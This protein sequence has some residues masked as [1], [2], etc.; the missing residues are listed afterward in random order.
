MSTKH[1]S[2]VLVLTSTFPRG[3]DDTIP[4][5]VLHLCQALKK[6]GWSSWV[7]APHAHGLKTRDEVGGI[8]CRRF[9]YAPARWE[10]LAYGGGMLANVRAERWRWLLLPSYL[11]SLLLHAAWLIGRRDIRIVHAHW[12]IP[13]GVVATLLKKIFWW[14]RIRVVITAHGGD[15]YSRFGGLA[16]SLMR[17]SMCEADVLAVVSEAMRAEAIAW[18]MPEDKVVVASMGVDTQCFLPPAG[19]AVRARRDII[20]VGRLVEKKG[21]THLLAALH[22]LRQR[23]SAARLRIVGDGPLRPLLEQQVQELGLAEAVDFL[24]AKPP[25]EIPAFFQAAS[26]FAMTSVVAPNGDQEGLGLV[27]A[28]AMACGCPVVAH[29]LPA[30]RDLVRHEETGLLTPQNDS[31]AL[32][33]AIERLLQDRTLS[34]RLTEAALVH[35]RRNYAWPAVAENYSRIY[36]AS[37]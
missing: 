24:G 3:A 36:Q 19:E 11:L 27:L 26:L 37:Y 5:F 35:V 13:Q 9:H 15:L 6:Q 32:A 30:V 1:P 33:D 34:L 12:I 25:A 17:W 31:P 16:A 22:L 28:E 20:F 29:E 10:Q 7:L 4:P 23:K 8:P 18:G 14:K 2:N 21:V